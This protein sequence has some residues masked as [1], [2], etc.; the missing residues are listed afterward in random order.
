MDSKLV[1]AMID[2][3]FSMIIIIYEFLCTLCGLITNLV[4]YFDQKHRQHKVFWLDWHSLIK[5]IVFFRIFL[6]ET[7]VDLQ[8]LAFFHNIKKKQHLLSLFV[9]YLCAD[10]VLQPIP[11]PI[12]V[13]DM[14]FI[15]HYFEICKLWKITFSVKTFLV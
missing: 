9:N 12:L 3:H 11:L 15:V 1:I 14:F 4:R 13:K 7:R 8:T 6:S 5:H 2:Y 10:N